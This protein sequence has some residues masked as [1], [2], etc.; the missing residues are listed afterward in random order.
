MDASIDRYG[1]L[2]HPPGT[3]F[4]YSNIGFGILDH[5]VTRHA[6]KSY[7]DFLRTEVFVPLGLTHTSVDLA[8]GLRELAATRY[9]DEDLPLPLYT[10]DHPGASDVWSSAHDL[11]RF[12]MFHL[13]HDPEGSGSVLSHEMRE[14]MQ[15]RET[16]G[17]EG[18]GYGLGWFVSDEFGFR[19]VSH[20]GSM[21]GVATMLAL[22]PDEDVAIVVLMNSLEREP[23]YDIERA[24]AEV[25]IP[26]FREARARAGAPVA[27]TPGP[28]QPDASLL[29]TWRGAV[30][31]WSGPVPLELVFQDDGDVH[32]KL[33]DQLPTVLSETRLQ[34]GYLVGRF[35]GRIPTED[36]LRHPHTV[37]LSLRV[38]EG[39]LA[40]EA[41]AQTGLTYFSLT[42]WVSLERQRP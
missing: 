1:V 2:V 13:G 32:V 23:R 18:E 20:T 41:T 17:T 35:G 10:T 40:G 6:G 16:P 14:R 15:R 9:D 7:A 39:R 26:G 29:G 31:T 11:V 25:V 19:K 22:Y 28:F 4:H 30:A 8:P 38:A 24:V 3:R 34:D 37:Q 33:G 36:A 12:G 21:P 27:A 5:L 42:S